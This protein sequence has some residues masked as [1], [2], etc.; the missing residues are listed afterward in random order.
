MHLVTEMK[1]KQLI[2]S[3]SISREKE[4]EKEGERNGESFRARGHS[5]CNTNF[6]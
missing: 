5:K 6:L 1:T 2:E 3:R 4:E